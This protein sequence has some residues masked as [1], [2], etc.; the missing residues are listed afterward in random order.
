MI[1]L[2]KKLSECGVFGVSTDEYL[3]YAMRNREEWESRGKEVVAG[4]VE[5]LN[6]MLP[7]RF[8]YR[9]PVVERLKADP[10]APLSRRGFRGSAYVVQ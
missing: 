7:R 1:P 9:Q 6:G 3:S 4:M 10:P 8:K 5:K 2:T